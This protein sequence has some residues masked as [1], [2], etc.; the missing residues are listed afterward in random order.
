MPISKLPLAAREP[1]PLNDAVN[2]L[3]LGYWMVIVVSVFV[4]TACIW[5]SRSNPLAKMILTLLLAGA[6]QL[7]VELRP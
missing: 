2:A 7:A 5:R 1:T 6:I 4:A 3:A